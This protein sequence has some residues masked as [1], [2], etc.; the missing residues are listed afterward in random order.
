M[1]DVRWSSAST[2]S[3]RAVFTTHS[4]VRPDENAVKC[5]RPDLLSKSLGKAAAQP[6]FSM[7]EMPEKAASG[8]RS[9]SKGRKPRQ[10]EAEARA[11]EL[12][13]LTSDYVERLKTILAGRKD[14]S[15]L[16]TQCAVQ[17]EIQNCA[18]IRPEMKVEVCALA[19][20]AIRV[21]AKESC[22]EPVQQPAKP[23]NSEFT[24][25]G[26]SAFTRQ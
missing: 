10:V 21:A 8:P 13:Q 4:V 2:A 5:K 19:M 20:H 17:R 23:L 14:Q 15:R 25:S 3:S 1:R 22:A 6:F 18:E 24:I 11:E 16:E 7:T 26:N 12:K 9:P